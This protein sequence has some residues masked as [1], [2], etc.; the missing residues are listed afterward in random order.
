MLETMRGVGHSWEADNF[1]TL[2]ASVRGSKVYSESGGTCSG[3]YCCWN[4]LPR[5]TWRLAGRTVMSL[6]SI[7]G[8]PASTSTSRFSMYSESGGMLHGR[9][10]STNSPGQ[11][12]IDVGVERSTIARRAAEYTVAETVAKDH[13]ALSWA[14]CN[15]VSF[16]KGCLLRRW[17][18]SLGLMRSAS[19][20]RH[21]GGM[22]HL[23]GGQTG[24]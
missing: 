14:Y 7:K 6:V 10:T 13:L 3:V 4:R 12:V 9:S 11:T 2:G 20:W 19:R 18:L 15:V 21:E 17:N 8:V 22:S 5:I 23:L 16:H 1:L 24:S